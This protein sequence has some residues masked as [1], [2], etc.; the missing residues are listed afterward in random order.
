MFFV[1]PGA[2]LGLLVVYSLGWALYHVITYLPDQTGSL[3]AIISG[4]TAEAFTH[5]PQSFVIGGFALIFA[6]QLI[7]LGILSAQSKRYFEEMW[8]QGH[9]YSGRLEEASE[10]PGCTVDNDQAPTQRET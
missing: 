5:S 3:D 9:T 6:F 4:A 2:L 1:L 7:S 10:D 8:F